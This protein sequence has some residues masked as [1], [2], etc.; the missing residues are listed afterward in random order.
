MHSVDDILVCLCDLMNMWVDILVDLMLF[1]EGMVYVMEI[2][3]E[4]ESIIR[5]DC[6]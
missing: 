4:K 3:M 2:W 5:V 1:I 6:Y